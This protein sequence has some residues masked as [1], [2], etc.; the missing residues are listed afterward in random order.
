MNDTKVCFSCKVSFPLSEFYF[1]EKENRRHGICKACRVKMQ[2]PI[3]KTH[4]Q[5]NKS[6][7]FER[8]KK[9]R[10]SITNFIRQYKIDNNVCTDCKISHPYWRLEFDHLPGSDKEIIVSRIHVHGWS[11]D[12]ILSEIAKCELVCSNCHRDRTHTRYEA[13]K[14]ESCS[15]V[16]E[17]EEQQITNVGG[18]H[19]LSMKLEPVILKLRHAPVAQLVEHPA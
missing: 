6:L 1:H 12:R 17:M 5:A 15:E 9:R 4:Y 16:S 11:Q 8:N 3:N 13:N 19:A 7:Y 14:S 2:T 18:F 10:R